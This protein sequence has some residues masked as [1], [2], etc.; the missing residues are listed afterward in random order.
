[1]RIFTMVSITYFFISLG[2]ILGGS[3]LGGMAGFLT[4][5]PPLSEMAN[6][7]KGLKIWAIVAAIGGTFDAINNFERGYL[8]GS[9]ADI[10]KQIAWIISA[11]L[12]ARTGIIII[13]W[14]TQESFN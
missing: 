2:V 13:K 3:I 5:K 1:M 9:L 12:G 8:E 14:L 4:G 10:V 11:Y 7:A 6:L